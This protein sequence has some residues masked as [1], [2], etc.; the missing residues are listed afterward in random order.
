MATQTIKTVAGNTAP[1]LELTAQRNGVD[2]NLSG[3][4]VDLII[5]LNGDVTNAGHQAC[6]V[7]D[8]ANGLVTY[9]RQHGDLPSANTYICDLKVTYGDGTF[10]VLYDQ[11]RLR[12]REPIVPVP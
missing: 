3:C 10:E 1:P 2:I 11:L 8:S 6:T 9:V 4:T 7:V 12:A 5:S